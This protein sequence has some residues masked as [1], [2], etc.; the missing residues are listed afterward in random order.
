MTNIQTLRN[1]FQIFTNACLG[2][3]FVAC[4]AAGKVAWEIAKFSILLLAS[5]TVLTYLG[6]SI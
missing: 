5:K 1:F 2:L 4:V 6:F 3:F